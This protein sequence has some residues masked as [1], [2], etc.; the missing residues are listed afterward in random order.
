[1]KSAWRLGFVQSNKNFRMTQNQ[2]P[3]RNHF[4]ITA[5]QQKK[6]QKNTLNNLNGFAKSWLSTLDFQN[7]I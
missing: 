6:K 2:T 7:D 1:M 4:G 3:N 5:E